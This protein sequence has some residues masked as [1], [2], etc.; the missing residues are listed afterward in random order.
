MILVCELLYEALCESVC[1]AARRCVQGWQRLC[2]WAVGFR[3]AAVKH[4]WALC[5]ISKDS[6]PSPHFKSVFPG[7]ALPP[8]LVLLYRLLVWTVFQL[9]WW[10]FGYVQTIW[11]WLVNDP[12]FCSQIAARKPFRFMTDFGSLWKAPKCFLFICNKPFSD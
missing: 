7:C 1:Q 2:W 4:V 6:P 12:F 11:G 5:F 8:T 10:Q 9:S 3:V